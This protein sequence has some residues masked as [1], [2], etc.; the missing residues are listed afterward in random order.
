MFS[1]EAERLP[2]KEILLAEAARSD[3]GEG[4]VSVSA[5]SAVCGRR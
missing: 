4:R 3:C 5:G 1:H 2:K